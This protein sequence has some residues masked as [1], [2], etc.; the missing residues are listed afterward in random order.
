VHTQLSRMKS[1][2]LLSLVSHEIRGRVRTSRVGSRAS[3]EM[4][5]PRVDLGGNVAFNASGRQAQGG[6]QQ[7][8]QHQPTAAMKFLPNQSK[9]VSLAKK[10]TKGENRDSGRPTLPIKQPKGTILN[11]PR[12]SCGRTSVGGMDSGRTSDEGTTTGGGGGGLSRV[13]SFGQLRL[14]RL[15]SY[16]DN[17]D[18]AAAAAAAAAAETKNNDMLCT[19]YSLSR[20]QKFTYTQIF[21]NLSQRAQT[22]GGVQEEKTLDISNLRHATMDCG[23]YVTESEISELKSSL[24]L[25][26]ANRLSLEQFLKFM[27][28][29]SMAPMSIDVRKGHYDMYTKYAK[30]PKA[31]LNVNELYLMLQHEKYDNPPAIKEELDNIINQWG[32]KKKRTLNFKQFISMM[33]YSQMQNRLEKLV[34]KRAFRL[35][36]RAKKIRVDDIKET[37]LNITG[38]SLS[39]EIAAE[40]LWEADV[41]GKGFL[42]KDD[43]LQTVITVYKPGYVYLWDYQTNKTQSFRLDHM[44]EKDLQR[45]DHG[46][47]DWQLKMGL[48]TKIMEEVNWS[49]SDFSDIEE[50]DNKVQSVLSTRAMEM[51]TIKERRLKVKD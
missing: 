29:L 5:I 49:D 38:K 32:N 21:K 15:A 45:F 17:S 46:I 41:K 44:E 48:D 12:H 43:F 31:G 19:E 8:K 10:K 13:D 37:I 4:A 33:A 9:F 40:M 2:R 50:D 20:H 24:D 39:D 27:V 7:Q 30:N 25:S 16:S 36:T 22:W 47:R 11:R 14:T 6:P 34:E 18:A 26:Y 1:R 42:D 35:F 23:H 51:A 3:S 28:K